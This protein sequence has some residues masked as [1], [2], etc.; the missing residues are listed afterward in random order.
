MRRAFDIPK[1]LAEIRVGT[2]W[3]RSTGQAR[4]RG[5]AEIAHYPLGVRRPAAM[6]AMFAIAEREAGARSAC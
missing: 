3:A 5:P 6:A 1:A 4:N 2:R